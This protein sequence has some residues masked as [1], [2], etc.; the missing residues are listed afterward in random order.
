MLEKNYYYKTI[1]S[2]VGALWLVASDK[3]L[4]AVLFK[5]GRGA[6]L[7]F[8]GRF[9]QNDL[10][11]IL[12]TAGQQ[13]AEYFKGI[14]KAFDV[15]LDMQGSV[16]QQKSWRVLQKIPYA[17]TISYGEQAKRLGDSNKARAVGMA[18]GRN[19]LSIVVPCHRVVGATGALTGFGGG[20][21]AKQFL[22][23]HEKKHAC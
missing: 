5:G 3:G 11:P 4:C 10:H 15:P 16:F 17:K 19:P 21:K 9:E 8:K 20:L 23:D 14:R 7:L 18:N 2:P 22:L 6:D 13:L 1:D 12:K